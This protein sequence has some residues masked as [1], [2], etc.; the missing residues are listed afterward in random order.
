MKR[1]VY[2]LFLGLSVM[3]CSKDEIPGDQL[4]KSFTEPLL[5]FGAFKEEIIEAVG[6]PDHIWGDENSRSIQL[7]YFEPQDGLT[8]IV[9]SFQDYIVYDGH[10]YTVSEASF[11][12]NRHNFEFIFDFLTNKYGEAHEY[13]EGLGLAN[14]MYG[15]YK[16]E[17]E[18]FGLT[19]YRPL[20]DWDE[21]SNLLL[22]Y[23]DIFS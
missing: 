14:K 4:V 10:G 5:N 12:T 17:F 6:E 15:W 23:Y 1:V 13:H 18:D 22:V 16:W 3:T 8:S 20:E 2:L 21:E 9:Y 19:F 11:Y 7:F